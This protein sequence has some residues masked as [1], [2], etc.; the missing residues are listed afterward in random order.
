VRPGILRGCQSARIACYLCIEASERQGCTVAKRRLRTLALASQKGGAGKTTLALHLAV[1]ASQA[2]LRT[3]LVDCDPQRSAAGWWHSRQATQPELVETEPA[4]LHELIP[5]AEADGAD[6]LILD[7]RPSVE[8]D[9]LDVARAASFVLIPT[10]PAILD[11]RAIG[12]TVEVVK[13]AGTRAAI[14]LNACPPAPRAGAEAALTMEARRSLEAAHGLPVVPA[15]ITQR[16]ALAH[17]LIDGRAVT[18]FEPTG[19]AAA[20]LRALWRYLENEAWQNARH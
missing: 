7:T 3:V 20:E 10:R 12:A 4:R 11:L 13:A 19:K 9:T 6:L 8:R 14:V 18:E 16:A 2:G 17:A 1:I 5:A 15:A